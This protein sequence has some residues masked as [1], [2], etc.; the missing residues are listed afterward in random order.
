MAV[1]ALRPKHA[2]FVAEYLKDLNATQA[3]IRAGYATKNANVQGTRLLANASIAA[4]I[5]ERA[6][7]QLER[8]DISAGRVLEEAAR[9]AFSDVRSVFDDEGNLRPVHEW[10]DAAASAVAAVEVVTRRRP[11]EEK[12]VEHVHKVK[13]WDKVGALDKLMRHMGLLKDAAAPAGSGVTFTLT[14]DRPG[15]VAIQAVAVPTN[16]NGNGSQA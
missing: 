8:L 9:I 1:N 2:L 14:L 3:A 4:S 11:G 7:K 15:A 13:L 5:R 6:G 16:G 10:S 12:V